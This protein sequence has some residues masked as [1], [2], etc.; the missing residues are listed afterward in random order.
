MSN[1]FFQ[2]KQFRI[3]QER[4]AMKVGTDGTLLGSWA[5]LPALPAENRRPRVLDI[6]TGTGLIALMMAQRCDRAL[7]MAIDIDGDA[8]AQACSNVASSPFAERV[9]VKKIDIRCWKTE[10]PAMERFDTIVSNPP[11]FVNSLNCP[12]ENRTIARHSDSLSYKDLLKQVI[13]LLSD[14]GNFSLVIPTESISAIESEAAFEGL[15]L[16]RKC[17]IKTT[18][19]KNPKRVLMEFH[20]Y[21]SGHIDISEEVLETSPN[22]RSEW[23]SNLTKDFYL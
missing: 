12:D 6:G 15:I 5:A 21:P 22:V 17:L 11:Y 1:S 10:L 2:F 19:R 18:P 20:K 8:V 14:E 16:S 3:G 4:C 7:V 23:Y 13:R 9:E